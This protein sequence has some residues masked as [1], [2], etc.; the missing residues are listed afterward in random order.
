MNQ[1]PQMVASS[2]S[3][4]VVPMIQ[5]VRNQISIS[6]RELG[7][8]KGIVSDHITPDT[9][10]QAADPFGPPGCFGS[11]ASLLSGF[12]Q[13]VL[14]Q[15]MYPRKDSPCG[16]LSTGWTTSHLHRSIR[17]LSGVTPRLK[18]LGVD[19]SLV[20]ILFHLDLQIDLHT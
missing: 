18:L 13:T 10:Y 19:Q 6:L 8:D 16:R 5:V 3:S 15:E 14:S 20:V 17:R 11:S 12:H 1:G 4:V 7:M 9:R 2:H